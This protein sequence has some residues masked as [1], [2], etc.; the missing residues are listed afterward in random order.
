MNVNMDLNN[1]LYQVQNNLS[2]NNT[3]VAGQDTFLAMLTNMMTD[4]N[5]NQLPG[6]MDNT[7][8]NN[9]LMEI[10]IGNGADYLNLL[11]M[12]NADINKIIAEADV[13]ASDEGKTEKPDEESILENSYL[14][15]NYYNLIAPQIMGITENV[16]SNPDTYMLQDLNMLQNLNQGIYQNSLYSDGNASYSNVKPSVI[17]AEQPRAEQM[18]SEKAVL[19]PQAE[20]LITEIESRRSKLKND[21]NSNAEML[22]ASVNKGITSEN[23]KI[24]QLNDESTQIKSQVLDQVKDNI[25]ML[26][27]INTVDGNTAKQVTMELYPRELGKVDIK[28]T[29]V[30]NKM[31]VEVKALNEETQKI[32]ASGADELLK[33][34]NKTV[35]TINI[36]IKS[37][38]SSQEHHLTNYY[39]KEN[40]NNEYNQDDQNLDHD[41]KRRNH[42]FYDDDGKSSDDDTFSELINLRS[43]KISP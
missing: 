11:S 10:L 5:L 25:I 36:V 35:E 24:I 22:N 6:T 31:T 43:A 28:M 3:S 12:N 1:I 15:Q 13:F 17:D 42:Y 16:S 7:E 19:S 20:K 8:I 40:Q 34:L 27:D 30:D 9:E 33:A 39:D 21:I 26:K 41:N 2:M 37:N 32:L 18:Y 29:V 4:D 14:M 38:D 23:N